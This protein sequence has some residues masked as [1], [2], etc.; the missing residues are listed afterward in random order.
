MDNFHEEMS[1]SHP[2]AN[3][4]FLF[5]FYTLQYNV[6]KIILKCIKYYTNKGYIST[7]I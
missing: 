2:T 4:D 7:L 1:S 6:K 5:F 3:I